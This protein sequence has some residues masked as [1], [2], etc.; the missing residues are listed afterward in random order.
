MEK[1]VACVLFSFQR[2]RGLCSVVI[3]KEAWAAF[4][5]HSKGGVA[6]VQFERGRGFTWSSLETEP[7]FGCGHDECLEQYKGKWALRECK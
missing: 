2:R 1:G 4:C 5:G 6:C 7:A 3:P